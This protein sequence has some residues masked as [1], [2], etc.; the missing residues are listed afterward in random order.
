MSR[1]IRPSA[2]EI[3]VDRPGEAPITLYPERR[4]YP[5][6]AQLRPRNTAIT[7]NGFGDLYLALG[8]A[9]RPWRLGV[10]RLLQPARPVDL[11]RRDPRRAGRDRLTERPTVPL[12]RRRGPRSAGG[13]PGARLTRDDPAAA[14]CG[15]AADRNRRDRR[16]G[17]SSPLSDWPIRRS[18]R[19]PGSSARNCV[20]SSARTSR[21]TSRTP[22]SLT[23]CASCC[24]S[25]WSPATPISRCWITLWR[26]TGSSSCST[27]PSSR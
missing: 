1:I 7:T 8:R 16:P 27:R 14:P 12:A 13:S 3:I 6:A 23:I 11:V 17:R 15:G 5:I 10:A 21:S 9:R 4:W 22:I 19:A 18:R 24:A 25:A 20:A 2:R 26:A